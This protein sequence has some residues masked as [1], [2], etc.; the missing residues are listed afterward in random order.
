ML[1]LV[2]FCPL[3]S[4]GTSTQ[5]VEFLYGLDEFF[6]LLSHLK[7]LSPYPSDL[8]FILPLHTKNVLLS[9]KFPPLPINTLP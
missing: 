4:R 2:E 1:E 5:L 6:S 9:V 7:G 3:Q 8:S